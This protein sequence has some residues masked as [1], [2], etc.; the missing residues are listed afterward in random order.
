[1]ELAVAVLSWRLLGIEGWTGQASNYGENAT[2]LATADAGTC[3]RRKQLQ[4]NGTT[5]FEMV[6]AFST[7]RLKY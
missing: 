6:Q 3:R 1:M 2:S 4:K 5:T 7:I